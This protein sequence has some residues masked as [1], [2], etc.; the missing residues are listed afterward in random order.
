[1]W[2]SKEK[3]AAKH[4]IM[5]FINPFLEVYTNQMT[6]PVH[7]FVRQMLYGIIKSRSV[8]VQRIA[9]SLEE[10]IRLKKVCERLYRNLAA[11]SVLNELLMEAQISRIAQEIRYDSAII[12]DLSDINK[13]NA[14]QMEGLAKV[15]DGSASRTDK[16]YFTLQASV[17]HL[18]KPREVHL[19]YSEL[20]SLVQE[21]TSE[22][23]KILDFIHSVII[24]TGNKGIFVMDRGMDGIKILKD[25]IQNGVSFMIRGDNRQLMYEGC[26][27]SEREIANTTKLDLQVISKGRTFSAGIVPV[28]LALPNDE[29]SKHQRKKK[30]DLYLVIAKEPAKGYVYYL[31]HF[32]HSYTSEAMMSLTIKYYGLRWGIEEVHRQIKQ[33]F[34]WEDI[35]LQNYYSLKNMNALLWMAASFI[36]NQVSKITIYLIQKI[37]EYLV[38]RQLKKEMS[39][40]LIYRITAVVSQVFSLIKLTKPPQKNVRK[41]FISFV[42]KEQLCLYLND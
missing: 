3:Q 33:D 39:I 23:T 38:Y 15:W 30:A 7:K 20:F 22:N 34:N 37:P 31:C 41:K 32:R 9:I 14:N 4:Y 13:S 2:L 21:D 42:N 36:Y 18:D 6:L 5:S 29:D 11:C 40:N 26:E 12:I 35:Q 1:M 16:G 17:C 24:H 8:I 25:L 10:S 27:M 19:L 28:Q